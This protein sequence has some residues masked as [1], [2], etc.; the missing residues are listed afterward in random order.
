MAFNRIAVDCSGL[1]WW[2]N[3]QEESRRVDDW[4]GLQCIR[5]IGRDCRALEDAL[6]DIERHSCNKEGEERG[7]RAVR[8]LIRTISDESD[9]NF[10]H[11]LDL[12]NGT[13]G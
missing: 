4:Q 2:A 5:R 11:V 6:K 1:Q 8:A 13:V 12:L 10:G 9:N 7:Q 3:T